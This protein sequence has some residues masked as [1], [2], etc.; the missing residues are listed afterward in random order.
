[1][2]FVIPIVLLRGRWFMTIGKVI[3][4]GAENTEFEIVHYTHTHP[5]I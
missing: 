2:G 5:I 3:A 4:S 1:M